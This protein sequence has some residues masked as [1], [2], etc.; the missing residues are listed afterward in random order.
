MLDINRQPWLGGRCRGVVIFV[1]SAV[2]YASFIILDTRSQLSQ[3]YAMEGSRRLTEISS[4]VEPQFEAQV[5]LRRWLDP[6]PPVLTGK[7][8]NATNIRWIGNSFH[9]PSHSSDTKS[10]LYT[11]HQIQKA[12]RH[13]SI[14]L[15]GDSTF[16]RVYGTLHGILSYDVWFGS[17]THLPRGFPSQVPN[18]P[19]GIPATY[20]VRR[21]LDVPNKGVDQDEL[22]SLLLHSPSPIDPRLLDHRAIIDVNKEFLT[23]PCRRMSPYVSM[24]EQNENVNSTVS[25]LPKSSQFEIKVCRSHPTGGWLPPRNADIPIPQQQPHPS[26]FPLLYDYINTN[27]LGNIYDFVTSELLTLQSITRHYTMYI[28]GPGVWETVK[29]TA[30]H[31]PFFDTMNLKQIQWPE[32]LYQLLQLTLEKLAMLAEQSPNLLIIW[33]TSGYYDGDE[34]SYVIQELNRRAT[35]Y[36]EDWNENHRRRGRPEQ[37]NFLSVDFGSAIEH[38]SH[39]KQRLRGDMQAHYGLEA[40]ILQVQMLTNLLYEYGRAQ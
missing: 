10:Q 37:S 6:P 29:Q 3:F 26:H 19:F 23:E 7:V 27:C 40:R 5:H 2:A 35:G 9:F 16:R 36:I 4:K 12:F 33:R 17:T 8:W 30:C 1:I 28:V 34:Q 21:G 38:R 31:H 13:H 11:P 25:A 22:L 39:G 15:Q 18:P 20:F 14:L 24:M 32:T